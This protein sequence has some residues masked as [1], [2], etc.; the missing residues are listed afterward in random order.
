MLKNNYMLV[1]P[2]Q[3]TLGAEHPTVRPV[4]IGKLFGLGSENSRARIGKQWPQDRKTAERCAPW[5]GKQPS[6]AGSG[7]ENFRAMKSPDRKT[8]DPGSEKSIVDQENM[9]KT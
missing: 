4:F 3:N 2:E 1:C 8:L 9:T 7:S 5:I 6:E